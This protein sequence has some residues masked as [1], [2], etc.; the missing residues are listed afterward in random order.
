MGVLWTCS[1]S[2]CCWCGEHCPTPSIRWA[3]QAEGTARSRTSSTPSPHNRTSSQVTK[4]VGGR[5]LQWL[6]VQPPPPRPRPQRPWA[7]GSLP[8]L[9]LLYFTHCLAG[10]GRAGRLPSPSSTRD[11]C[12]HFL[13]GQV[14]AHSRPGAQGLA[15]LSLRLQKVP[16]LC[17]A[18]RT[19]P[20]VQMRTRGSRNQG[21]A[22]DTHMQVTPVW[23]PGVSFMTHSTRSQCDLT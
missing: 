10:P 22:Q 21:L 23:A 17:L 6:W 12:C 7:L 14:Q 11:P 20:T 8:I 1:P 5:C 18:A 3:V 13:H 19:T 15:R 16:H 4:A 2:H 9:L